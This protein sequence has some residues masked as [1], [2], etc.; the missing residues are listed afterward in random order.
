[1]AQVFLHS[2]QLGPQVGIAF[3][4]GVSSKG[5]RLR[6]ARS[7]FRS[8][9]TPTGVCPR[10][11]G[12]DGRPRALRV[13]TACSPCATHHPNRRPQEQSSVR[14]LLVRV[15]R[16]GLSRFVHLR[17]ESLRLLWRDRTQQIKRPRQDD[18]RLPQAMVP[19]RRLQNLV[20]S[21]PMRRPR[22]LQAAR[23][24]P[25]VF[26]AREPESPATV[27]L[28]SE[29]QALEQRSPKPTAIA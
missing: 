7:R 11:P 16:R 29:L 21:M 13:P 3:G 25:A 1:M 18:D 17:Q 6:F 9:S 23:R 4:S 20:A 12:R 15:V 14:P 27:R 22:P 2:V 5:M 26:R 19:W 28:A 8:T 10:A 24:G